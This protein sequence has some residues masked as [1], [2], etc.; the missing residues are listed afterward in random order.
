MIQQLR[1]SYKDSYR[2]R[3]QLLDDL[4]DKEKQLFTK[5]CNDLQLNYKN[6]PGF[7]FIQFTHS[8]LLDT[9]SYVW[10]LWFYSQHIRKNAIK[11]D[12]PILS[13]NQVYKDLCKLIDKGCFRI[14]KGCEQKY[15]KHLIY[16][17]VSVY[18][19]LGVLVDIDKEKKEIRYDQ[20]PIFQQLE[21][22]LFIELYYNYIQPM[23][24]VN[25]D[26]KNNKIPENVRK[27]VFYFQNKWMNTKTGYFI[28]DEYKLPKKDKVSH[29]VIYTEK[30]LLDQAL[31]LLSEEQKSAISYYLKKHP[32][33]AEQ[34]CDLLVQHHGANGTKNANGKY[35][36][37][38][39]VEEY[40]FSSL[41]LWK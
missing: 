35:K 8:F 12:S 13:M 5:I 29:V 26:F 1:E 22:N 10:Q 37:L 2:K 25:F 23:L 17:C 11:Q 3:H 27:A 20:I 41:W 34:I 19:D 33:T 32:Y 31:K 7:F 21:N 39:Y 6:L 14:N 18:K 28:G 40:I 38:P 15:L 30:N 9:P 24:N 4:T 36:I 16:E